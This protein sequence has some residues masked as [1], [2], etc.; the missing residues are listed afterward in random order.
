MLSVDDRKIVHLL[1]EKELV[2]VAHTARELIKRLFGCLYEFSDFTISNWQSEVANGDTE[3]G[4]LDW[5][6]EQARM[7]IDNKE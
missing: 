1:V 2:E 3:S 6:I 7:S 4:Y 5:V